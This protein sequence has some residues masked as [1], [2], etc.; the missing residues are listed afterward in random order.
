MLC[1]QTVIKEDLPRKAKSLSSD[2]DELLNEAK[3]TQKKL[4]QGIGGVQQG[5]SGTLNNLWSV[6]SEF[7]CQ[8]RAYFMNS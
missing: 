6:P 1:F 3:I 8:R 5:Y 4:Q 7:Q 2:S